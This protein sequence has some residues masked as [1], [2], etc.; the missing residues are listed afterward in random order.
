MKNWF[1]HLLLFFS[2]E[3]WTTSNVEDVIVRCN[4]YGY[5]Q[6]IIEARLVTE[7]SNKGNK[8]YWMHEPDYMPYLIDIKTKRP[9][10]NQPLISKKTGLPVKT[11]GGW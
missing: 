7:Q 9:I 4:A 8:R 1:N 5:T 11:Y 10:S 2:K 6:A 3:T